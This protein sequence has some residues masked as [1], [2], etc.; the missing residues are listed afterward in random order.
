MP[1]EALSICSGDSNFVSLMVGSVKGRGFNAEIA[2]EDAG[3][4]EGIFFY[5]NSPWVHFCVLRVFLCELC[6]KF[7]LLFDSWPVEIFF[8]DRAVLGQDR[9]RR[10]R[11][12]AGL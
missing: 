12:A 10:G 11:A 6:V 7:F 1:R 9:L 5:P 8:D 2:E 4:A 3:D